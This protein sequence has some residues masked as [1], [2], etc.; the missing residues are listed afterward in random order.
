[1]PK[2]QQL[3]K[4]KVILD[5]LSPDTTIIFVKNDTEM[6][7]RMKNCIEVSIKMAKEELCK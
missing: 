5:R 4:L 1:M 6:S 2:Q 7:E 3:R